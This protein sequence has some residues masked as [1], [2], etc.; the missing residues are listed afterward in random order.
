MR[1]QF[2]RLGIASLSYID[3]VLVCIGYSI[4]WACIFVC[5]DIIYRYYIL[6]IV[7]ALH[8]ELPVDLC[9]CDLYSA[10]GVPPGEALQVGG[11]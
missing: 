4:E 11:L 1:N 3:I 10:D 6:Y 9:E 7:Q 5:L 8:P 2:L